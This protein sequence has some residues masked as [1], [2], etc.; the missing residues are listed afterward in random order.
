MAP[1]FEETMMEEGLE[2]EDIYEMD[3]NGERREWKP[4][5]PEEMSGERK[6]WLVVARLK[7]PS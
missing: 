4:D 3:A 1:F 2:I 6:K 7:R 5:A